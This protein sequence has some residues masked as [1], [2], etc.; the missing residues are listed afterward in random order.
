MKSRTLL[1]TSLEQFGFGNKTGVQLPF[2]WAGRVPDSATKKA[3]VDKGVLAKGEVPRLVVGDNVQVAIGQGLMAA[4]PLQLADAYAVFANGGTLLTPGI[5]RAVWAP[6]TPDSAPAVADLSRGRILQR[7]DH[8]V[9]RGK[10]EMPPDTL[11]P[12]VAGLHRVTHGP[13]VT[14]GFYHYTT[15]ELLFKGMP[16]EVAGKTGTAQGAGSLPWNDSSVFGA[17]SEDK[18]WP[19]TVVSYLEKSGFGAK[20]AAPVTKCVFLAL[21]KKVRTDPVL[22]SNPL[23]LYSSVAAKPLTLKNSA[24]LGVRSN[25]GRG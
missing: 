24:C 1:K 17:F 23:N 2:E 13:G 21:S 16:L 25:G 20:A 22:I 4:T 14:W 5:V 19:Y 7:F 12:I 9:A 6:L 8:A 18:R 3:L 11:L 10:L 15:G